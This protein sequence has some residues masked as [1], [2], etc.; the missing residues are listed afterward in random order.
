MNQMPESA[1]A[2]AA[3]G[4]A[5]RGAA[6]RRERRRPCRASPCASAQEIQGEQRRHGGEQQRI[7]AVVEPPR[8]RDRVGADQ[9]PDQRIRHAQQHEPAGQGRGGMGAGL[10]PGHDDGNGQGD[11][12]I[13]RRA[14]A[15]AR[16]TASGWRTEHAHGRVGS[17]PERSH[18]DRL[19]RRRG[20]QVDGRGDRRSEPDHQACEDGFQRSA[21]SAR[22]AERGRQQEQC[23]QQ[24]SGAE[25][26]VVAPE[27]GGRA[28]LLPGTSV[29]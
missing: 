24:R 14:S 7:G 6:R 29:P 26:D 22:Q 21:R 23:R 16:P 5:D 28:R 12:E 19:A 18:V 25:V 15:T 10:S 17:G 8:R 11:P 9:D 13:R 3:G 4:R 27:E 2:A 20:E 1:G